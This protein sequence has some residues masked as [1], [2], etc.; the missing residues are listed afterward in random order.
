MQSV[1]TTAWFGSLP[2]Y[3]GAKFETTWRQFISLLLINCTPAMLRISIGASPD[4]AGD[5]KYP[6][7]VRPRRESGGE[8]AKAGVPPL[9]GG[10]NGQFTKSRSQRSRWIWLGPKA[11]NPG[12]VGDLRVARDQ[13]KIQCDSGRRDQAVTALRDCEEPLCDV[14]D[15]GSELRIVILAA[16]ERG[17]PPFFKW[18]GEIYPTFVTG[19]A[20]LRQYEGR[21]IDGALPLVGV[22]EEPACMPSEAFTVAINCPDER[23]CVGDGE[24]RSFA[25]TCLFA[26]RRQLFLPQRIC[27]ASNVGK[28][29]LYS[30]RDSNS[31]DD[32]DFS[33][34][35]A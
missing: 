29:I 15:L 8:F 27:I 12:G 14:H 13:R 28:G 24:R 18:Q 4:G 10:R 17:P 6:Q 30:F 1:L 33:S 26:E 11:L 3:R 31:T 22:I 34:T 20:K 23:V 16:R 25:S 32:R 21:N 35:S 7:E 5:E 2:R 19:F 9:L